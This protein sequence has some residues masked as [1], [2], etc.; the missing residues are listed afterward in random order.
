M[1]LAIASGQLTGPVTVVLEGK[2]CAGVPSGLVDGVLVHHA[3]GSGDDMLVALISDA[4]DQ[5]TLV[6][7][8]RELRGRAESLGAGVV[9]PKWLIERLE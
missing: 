2:S 4:P 5:V 6:T 3:P 7:A 1:R 8:D 9:G